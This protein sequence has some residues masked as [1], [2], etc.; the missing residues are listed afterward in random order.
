[1]KLCTIVDTWTADR[2][3]MASPRTPLIPVERSRWRLRTML[4]RRCTLQ[5]PRHP[6]LFAKARLYKGDFPKR[7]TQET[8]SMQVCHFSRSVVNVV[9][10]ATYGS[11]AVVR[12]RLTVR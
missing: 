10:V 12:I 4:Y 11:R 9:R 1:M 8:H 5:R 6:W 3:Y 2:R 7:C